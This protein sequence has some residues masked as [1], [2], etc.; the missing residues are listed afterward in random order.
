MKEFGL[1]FMAFFA[2]MNPLSNLPAYYGSCG[3]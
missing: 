3:R 1:M 2:I